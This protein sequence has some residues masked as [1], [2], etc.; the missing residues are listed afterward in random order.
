M[1]SVHL[2]VIEWQ[3]RFNLDVAELDEAHR[4]LFSIVNKVTDLVQRK[5]GEKFA[6]I[7]GIKYLRAY[8]LRHFKEEEA[9][10]RQIG[11]PGY[12]AHKR[13]H[14]ELRD[15]T[16]PALQRELEETD[17]STEAV[18]RFLGCCSGWLSRHIIEED[19]AIVGKHRPKPTHFQEGSEGAVLKEIIAFPMRELF[20]VE[21]QVVSSLYDEKKL[22]ESSY[23]ELIYSWQ[24]EP[25]LRV[26]LI[27]EDALLLELLE[28]LMNIHFEQREEISSSAIRE[29]AQILMQHTADHFGDDDIHYKMSSDRFLTAEECHGEFAERYPQHSMIFGIGE[30]R[31]ALCLDLLNQRAAAKA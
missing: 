25:Q 2:R 26:V 24:E 23:Y 13:L 12:P 6:C 17:Y 1:R 28:Q 14:D 11:Y 15:E 5:R 27:I 7:E 3:D 10:M 22:G 18:Q 30:K 31:M 20:G 19:Q 16:L 29:L 8:T 9:F 4:Q 21:V